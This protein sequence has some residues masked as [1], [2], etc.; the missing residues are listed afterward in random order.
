MSFCYKQINQKDI[1]YY[2]FKSNNIIYIYINNGETIWFEQLR[3]LV[4]E[5]G[6]KISKK[7]LI[8]LIKTLN[9]DNTFLNL[10]KTI[11]IDDKQF[12]P[13]QLIIKRE[14]LY[15][16][17]SITAPH[18]SELEDCFREKICPDSEIFIQN[19]TK[20]GIDWIIEYI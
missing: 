19:I 15:F 17:N 14:Q 8:E 10:N 2:A 11:F 3:F 7:K 5:N 20:L 1:K 9:I 16:S 12:N 4:D 13:S 18:H 6:Q